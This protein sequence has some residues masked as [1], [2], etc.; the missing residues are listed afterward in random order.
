MEP[1]EL[2]DLGQSILFVAVLH[3]RGRGSGVDVELPFFGV[4]S[5]RADKFSSGRAFTT[6]AEALEA[7]GLSE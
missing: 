7:V 4:L 2:R 1:R 3:G 5:L 6:E